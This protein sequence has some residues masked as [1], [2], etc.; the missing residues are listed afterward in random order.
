MSQLTEPDRAIY[1]SR[2][3]AIER[4]ATCRARGVY[5]DRP[6]FKLAHVA[7]NV[8]GLY[9]YQQAGVRWLVRQR[10]CLLG[11]EPGLGKTAQV[12]RSLAGPAIVVA[13]ASLRLVWR[14]ETK[15]WR[16]DYRVILPRAGEL[17]VPRGKEIVV[18]SYDSLPRPAG[19]TRLVAQSLGHVL[20]VL[21]EAHKV[22]G[23]ETERT[24]R[25]RLLT[26]QVERVW[27]LTGTPLVGTPTDLWGLLVS[28]R[29][30]KASFGDEET[31]LDA[32][33]GRRGTWGMK[34]PT[35]P[36][37][38]D[39]IKACLAKVMLRR[40][41]EDVL[42]DLPK[43]RY[44]I[45]RVAPPEDLLDELQEANAAWE[46]IG[47][48][49]LPPFE[50]LSSLRHALARSRIPALLELVEQREAAGPLLVFAA[51]VEPLLALEKRQGWGVM[52]GR[53][54]ARQRQALVDAFQAGKL[55]GLA[56]S[57]GVGGTGFTMTRAAHMIF[58]SRDYT[59]GVNKQAEDRMR[60]IGQNAKR[61]LITDLV[62]DHPVEERLHE[63]LANKREL[64]RNTVG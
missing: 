47:L 4:P 10:S 22:K 15:R 48:R 31:F 33:G 21:D 45:V 1:P 62:T 8:L 50:L 55:H 59:P 5:P 3:V 42:S 51:H 18:V 16:S 34:F 46:S 44:E 26:S 20:V 12:L 41:Q 7:L 35:T 38:P 60:R 36:R 30:D 25:V 39:F 63:I 23:D 40:L 53:T 58:A 29:L 37:R 2:A 13:P 9:D 17:P 43:T 6:I 52:T 56:C 24:H 19:K 57:I 54:P 28:A 27:A 61:V 14:D 49:D 11:D 64:I 32:F